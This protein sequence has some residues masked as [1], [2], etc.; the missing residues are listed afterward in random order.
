M[1]EFWEKCFIFGIL[2]VSLNIAW[3]S[4]TLF[5]VQI[6][7][8]IGTSEI[9]EASGLA[10]SRRYPGVLWTHNDLSCSFASFMT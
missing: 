10:T 2:F 9:Q 4:D 7:G 8:Y 3:A 1:T 6:A 5:S